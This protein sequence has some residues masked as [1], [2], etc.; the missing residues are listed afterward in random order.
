MT[1]VVEFPTHQKL[2]ADTDELDMF[3]EYATN[4]LFDECEEYGHDVMAEDLFPYV[5]LMVESVRAAVYKAYGIEHTLHLVAETV[6]EVT[7]D[8]SDVDPDVDPV[9]DQETEDQQEQ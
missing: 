3:V 9:D 1:N 2:T 5:A 6:V 4:L 8:E 7:D